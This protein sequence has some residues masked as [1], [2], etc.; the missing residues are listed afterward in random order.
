MI[1]APSPLLQYEHKSQRNPLSRLALHSL[2][3]LGDP[4]EDLF[5]VLVELELG[6]DDLGGGDGDGDALAVGLLADNALDVDGPL[7]TVDAGDTAL[8]ALVAATDND[9]LVVLADGD[10]A[11]LSRNWLDLAHSCRIVRS[12]R[13]PA[14]AFLP[15]HPRTVW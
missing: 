15:I 12:N 3:T 13:N 10:R 9:N 7:Q 1:P 6:D 4:L 11:D 2:T 14:H 5:T 8:T